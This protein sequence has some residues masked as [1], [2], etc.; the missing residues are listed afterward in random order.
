MNK[1]K[2]ISVEKKQID[3][4]NVNLFE[5]DILYENCPEKVIFMTLAEFLH[6]HH[7]IY[8]TAE[9]TSD[10]ILVRYL[11]YDSNITPILSSKKNDSNSLY[12]RTPIK[13]ECIVNDRLLSIPA[14]EPVYIK[15]FIYNNQVYELKS[16]HKLLEYFQHTFIVK[17]FVNMYK[18]EKAN[19]VQYIPYKEYTNI[20]SWFSPLE[21]KY[22]KYLL[23][24]KRQWLYNLDPIESLGTH[25]YLVLNALVE[26]M[27]HKSIKDYFQLKEIERN[28]SQE[29]LKSESIRLQYANIAKRYIIM[30]EKKFGSTVYQNI[31]FTLSKGKYL[32]LSGGSMAIP[33]LI[34][35]ITDPNK[36]LSLLT[37]EQQKVV[38]AE[39][40][41]ETEYINSVMLNKCP[42]INLLHKYISSKSK[43]YFDLLQNYIQ[44]TETDY[45]T[46]ENCKFIIF[47]KHKYE[48]INYEF[49]NLSQS[50][51]ASK[52]MPYA[53]K[54]K[55]NKVN[56]YYCKICGEK[57]LHDF[58]I[59]DKDIRT[60]HSTSYNEYEAEIDEFMWSVTLKA[61]SQTK[62]I[63]TDEKKI[64][65]SILNNIKPIIYKKI[66][67]L[68]DQSK[69]TIILYIY[70]YILNAVKT[71]NI[72]FFNLN[73][74]SV[75]VTKIADKI[76]TFIFQMYKSVII[77]SS[78]SIHKIKSEFNEC[79]KLITK[80]VDTSIPLSNLEYNIADYVFTNP[81]YMFA[82]M[83]Y[84]IM[85]PH[86]KKYDRLSD[87][88]KYEF[89]HIM[90]R[91]LPAIVKQ[92]KENYK[93]YKIE[94]YGKYPDTNLYAT[95]FEIND[96][97]LIEFLNGNTTLY[98][99][100]TYV[101]LC[102]YIKNDKKY[103]EYYNRFKVIEDEILLKK[104]HNLTSTINFNFNKSYQFAY[105]DVPI[106]CLYDEK[107]KKHKWNK[108]MYDTNHILIDIGCSI[109]GIKRS[110]INKLDVNAVW[111]SIDALSNI[112]AFFAFYKDR[113][114]E[115]ELHHWVNNMC[116][117]C[118][119]TTEDMN[120]KILQYYNKYIDKFN[121]TK[122]T[123]YEPKTNKYNIEIITKFVD[124]Y[125][126]VIKLA[127]LLKI[128]LNAILS[129][130]L[131]EG[132]DYNEILSGKLPDIEQY[133]LYNTQSELLYILSKITYSIKNT[134]TAT[135][136][137]M[138]N[139]ESNKTIHNF[140]IQSICEIILDFYNIDN[141]TAIDLFTTV[142]LNQKLLAKPSK[143]TIESVDDD[144]VYLGEDIVGEEMIK[145]E[146][147]IDLKM[148]DYD[149]TEDNPNNELNIDY[150]NEY[151][152]NNII[153]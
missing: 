5:L 147:S 98:V 150:P 82:Q 2:V 129:I 23:N 120:S 91:S 36:V 77:N 133:H 51:I 141:K 76:I 53:I 44:N 117:K 6:N 39:Y 108:Y 140:L 18:H 42:H 93:R 61:L 138:I 83:I 64:A 121:K 71:Q 52:L 37:P 3:I 74:K 30:I 63:F 99:L 131:T 12:T 114:P 118:M 87:K 145:E 126:I 40:K 94:D 84:K 1:I 111:K 55:I 104:H 47:C 26:G 50:N 72:T 137:S 25:F 13:K 73:I 62:D 45:I 67:K 106:T 130:G 22:I 101:L 75:N 112:D 59:D 16:I 102:K 115:N 68:T 15:S 134:Y 65:R 139:K 127:T 135:F 97:I 17:S 11:L 153:Y 38:I 79:Y 28:R 107:G 142:L 57:L 152:Y 90:G 32:R 41:K 31:L 10:T 122:E 60:K 8:N 116:T 144:I 29:L 19:I 103:I 105:I 95:L 24:D 4:R 88:I 78:Y 80:D 125:S 48:K 123:V 148:S 46:C 85:V 146:Y 96:K 43:K 56:E 143:I 132:V 20:T 21:T 49:H 110:E 34:V 113:C 69:I 7:Y 9:T 151:I 58:Y 14:D 119:L 92:F 81:I 35:N 54:I 70:S 109:C 128:E 89:E 66:T 27:Q 86:T 149:F 124:N 100:A 136:N 33:T